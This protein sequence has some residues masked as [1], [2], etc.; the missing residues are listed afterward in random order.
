MITFDHTWPRTGMVL[1]PL[2]LGAGTG[3]DYKEQTGW[4]L[5]LFALIDHVRASKVQ[6][7]PG[8]NR[9]I[10]FGRKEILLLLIHVSFW[11]WYFGHNRL[12]AWIRGYSGIGNRYEWRRTHWAVDVQTQ[13]ERF[14]RCCTFLTSQPVT[15][16]DVPMEPIP[17]SS[18]CHLMYKGYWNRKGGIFSLQQ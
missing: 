1:I 6:V 4:K 18:W 13:G 11:C 9:S 3:L 8:L 14:N 12:L 15:P 10:I 5:D 7:R 17:Y 16:S 2:D